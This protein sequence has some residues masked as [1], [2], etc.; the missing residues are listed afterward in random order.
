MYKLF[1][2]TAQVTNST[3]SVMSN[4]SVR[5]SVN[6]NKGGN[7][8]ASMRVEISDHDADGSL[9][10]ESSK[11]RSSMSSPLKSTFSTKDLTNLKMAAINS[12][13]SKA[14]F[15]ASGTSKN[16]NIPTS[17]P[18]GATPRETK[19]S[20][21]V[22]KTPV[23][24]AASLFSLEDFD[25]P[26]NDKEFVHRL[27]STILESQIA[28]AKSMQEDLMNF[29]QPA[30]PQPNQES[31]LDGAS[32][33][34]ILTSRQ[35]QFDP[36]PFQKVFEGSIQHLTML[37]NQADMNIHRLMSETQAIEQS[38]QR[39]MKEFLKDQ[40]QIFSQFRKVDGRISKVANNVV[41]IGE[42]LQTV[43]QQKQRCIKGMELINH[44]L[45]FNSGDP[46][47]IHRM[48]NSRHPDDLYEAAELI[49]TLYRIA[50][51]LRI[52]NTETAIKTISEK[53]GEIEKN[54]LDEFFKAASDSDVEAMKACAR[55]LLQF[56]G[57]H[58]NSQYLF[59]AVSE[60]DSSFNPENHGSIP[61]FVDRIRKLYEDVI[62]LCHKEYFIIQKVFPTPEILIRQL[63]ERLFQD[64]ITSFLEGTVAS[65]VNSKIDYIKVLEIAYDET[66]WLIRRL[67]EPL[68]ALPKSLEHSV[69]I[70]LDDQ[71]DILF[72]SYRA[73]Y[74]KIEL[75]TLT[76]QTRKKIETV[77]NFPINEYDEGK[78]DA[79][80]RGDFYTKWKRGKPSAADLKRWCESVLSSDCVDS[81][82]ILFQ[83]ALSRAEKLSDQGKAGHNIYKVFET[84]VS[85]LCL[86][87]FNVICETG[88]E[89]LPEA[90]PKFE[91]DLFFFRVVKG[92]TSGVQKLDT[93]LQD[94]VLPKLGSSLTAQKHCFNVKSDL[95]STM[96]TQ[97]VDGL[98]RCLD[99]TSKYLVKL[100]IKE[101]KKT[102]YR[103]REDGPLPDGTS[104]T[105][106]CLQVCKLIKN[107]SEAAYTFLDGKNL[108]SYLSVLGKRL[109][110]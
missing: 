72:Q 46:S 100:M 110:E 2:S 64:K 22:T 107:Q 61:K 89:L 19:I 40:E 30:S 57:G 3:V 84:L 96:E 81:L 67:K 33:P 99:A 45:N 1:R 17:T 44:F 85:N 70:V 76:E 101:Q 15:K 95:F 88:I 26:I 86:G 36:E 50:T 94:D 16:L 47:K 8:A 56:D 12:R 105:P 103:P 74:V 34:P 98:N 18:L 7:A 48:F 6:P 109:F 92:I 71:M 106:T 27:T 91:P 58:I 78:L 59:K 13:E 65:R 82:I 21:A 41:Q 32:P 4:N 79:A 9:N 75:Q 11:M 14:E 39:R 52:Q 43:N 28:A 53:A 93:H 80:S 97:M 37:K 31:K 73:S 5:Q 68:D 10:I 54:L 77:L 83:G 62:K 25:H 66:K 104:S 29:E 69:N 38:H 60:I 55:T 108:D 20:I 90:D 49:Q 35:L 42:R 87:F 102:D 23:P 24:L 51:D 63:L